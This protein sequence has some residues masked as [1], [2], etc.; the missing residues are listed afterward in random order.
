MV[1]QST[2]EQHAYISSAHLNNHLKNL[3]RPFAQGTDAPS[4]W[5]W[6]LDQR[7]S[8]SHAPVYMVLAGKMQ[9]VSPDPNSLPTRHRDRAQRCSNLNF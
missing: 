3:L 7:S 4:K 1:F 6:T 5:G 2:T 9:R 8:T